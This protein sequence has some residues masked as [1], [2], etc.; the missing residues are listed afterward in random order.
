[1][2]RPHPNRST[3]DYLVIG[4]DPPWIPHFFN[5]SL[6]FPHVEEAMRS[7][8]RFL[9]S[10]SGSQPPSRV[11]TVGVSRAS[12]SAI[13]RFKTE[14]LP[15]CEEYIDFVHAVVQSISSPES[16]G[17]IREDHFFPS[18]AV[19]PVAEVR[20][21]ANLVMRLMARMVEDDVLTRV[22]AEEGT[23]VLHPDCRPADYTADRGLTDIS[24]WVWTF[25]TWA[26]LDQ[27]AEKAVTNLEKFLKDLSPAER[28][29]V[30]VERKDTPPPS[31]VESKFEDDDVVIVKQ[32]KAA[33]SSIKARAPKLQ[34]KPQ[35]KPRRQ[36]HKR[37][38]PTR[39]SAST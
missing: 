3:I 25:K 12:S 27:V 31:K 24:H 23:Y 30:K 26:V 16:T 6:A 5:G 38:D 13:N 32:E 7:I 2:Y 15:S 18:M 33:S 34:S 22:S 21:R 11:P 19:T 8:E 39:E 20:K 10:E 1:M 9:D 28:S 29:R 14:E 35:A 17:T 4:D 36:K 37:T